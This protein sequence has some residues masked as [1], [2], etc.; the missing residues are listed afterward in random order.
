MDSPA[1]TPPLPPT[2]DT[3]VWPIHG[4]ITADYG[5]PHA[6][7][8]RYHSGIDISS[9]KRSGATPI[10][11]F[12][13]GKVTHVGRST[14]GYGNHVIVDHGGGLTSL[15]AHLSRI[16]VQIG[17]QIAPGEQLGFEGSSGMTTGPHLHFEIRVDGK[18]VNPRSVLT[19]NP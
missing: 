11:S 8:Q 5:V 13:A 18:A 16:T 19:G 10:V 2:Q 1:A 17:Q 9:G 3:A 4:R 14:Q 7:W 12:K 6:P 15:Y